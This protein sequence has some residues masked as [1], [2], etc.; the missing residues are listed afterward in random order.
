M[1]NLNCGGTSGDE[2]PRAEADFAA[3]DAKAGKP[4]GDTG[5][6]VSAPIAAA[7]AHEIV[8]D[9]I[10]PFGGSNWTVL[11]ASCE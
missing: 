8:A 9:A 3:N 5:A 11:L 2:R 7:S 1:C 4:G 6:A 10:G